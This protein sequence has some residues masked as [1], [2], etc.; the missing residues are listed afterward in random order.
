VLSVSLRSSIAHVSH[1]RVKPFHRRDGVAAA[2]ASDG[3]QNLSL[4]NRL[5]RP[6]S[7]SLHVRPFLREEEVIL[8]LVDEVSAGLVRFDEEVGTDSAHQKLWR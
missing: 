7:R 2:P 8:G 4:P 1:L 6:R 3:K 5:S